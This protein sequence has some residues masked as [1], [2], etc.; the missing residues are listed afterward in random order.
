[1][2]KWDTHPPFLTVDIAKQMVN[3]FFGAEAFRSEVGNKVA[4]YCDNDVI[5]T[6]SIFDH[7]QANYGAKTFENKEDT[8][9]DIQRTSLC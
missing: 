6:K 7:F 8:K 1:M 5:T 3:G 9:N 2:N 4:E